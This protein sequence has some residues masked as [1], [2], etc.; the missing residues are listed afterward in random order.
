MPSKG[1]S[2]EAQAAREALAEDPYNLHLIL[3][4]AHKYV[5]QGHVERAGNVLL[6]GWKRAGEIEDVH[7]RFCFLMKLCEV[8]YLL[9][10]FKQAMAV[11][12]DVAEPA[13]P[14]ERKSYH[15]LSCHVFGANKEVQKTLKAFQKAIE[16]EDFEMAVRI[17][18]LTLTDLKEVG[19]YSVAKSAIE[20]MAPEGEKD[21]TLAM[22]DGFATK[23]PDTSLRPDDIQRYFLMAA[24]VAAAAVLLGLLYWLEQWSLGRLKK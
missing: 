1:T 2:D 9:S 12:Q 4:L 13:D 22:L 18:A 3:E 17:Y 16:G 5:T 10:R 8:S 23:E 20:R 19:I 7:V 11:L 21:S 24:A 6:R 15:I 14:V